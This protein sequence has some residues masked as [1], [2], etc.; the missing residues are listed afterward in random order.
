[1]PIAADAWVRIGSFTSPLFSKDGSTLFHLRGTGLPQVWA[2]AL[3]GSNPRQ[4]SFHDEKV[5]FL[6][7]SPTD[8]RL[9]WGVDAGGDELQQFVLLNPGEE[10]RRIT[11]KPESIH[12]FGAWSAD[13]TRIAYATNDRDARLHDV[14]VMDLATGA[15]KRLVEG[16]G[17]LSIT[18]WSPEG[19]RFA[20]IEDFSSID[21]RLWIVDAITGRTRFVP[22]P[23]R[24]R[25]ASIR[26][27][28]DGTTL[29]GLTDCATEGAGG[30]EFMRLCRIDPVSGIATELYA[31]PGRDVEA[32]SLAPGGATL[33]TIENDR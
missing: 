2:V 32:W 6:R 3:D 18:S 24:T 8:D 20:V 26:W 15:T 19:A 7:R 23:S 25:Y 31:P 12:D 29:M 22:R 21:Q 33:A 17:I 27:S 14:C 9:I 10:P 5:A 1:M 11:S 16:P 13:G 4:F 30:A 28:A